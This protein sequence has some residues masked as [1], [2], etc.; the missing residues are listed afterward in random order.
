MT[1]EPLTPAC[2]ES[3]RSL[4][5]PAWLKPRKLPVFKVVANFEKFAW[6]RGAIESGKRVDAE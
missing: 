6:P 1:K 3:R 2:H 4:S 5:A